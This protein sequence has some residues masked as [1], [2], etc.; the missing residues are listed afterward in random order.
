MG[1]SNRTPLQTETP[2]RRVLRGAALL[3]L[4]LTLPTAARASAPARVP[5]GVWLYQ[6]EA[7]VKI[8]DCGGLMCGRIQWLQ[9]PRNA[10]GQLDR[11][12]HNPDP[13]LRQRQLCGV[14]MIWN[15]HPDGPSRWRDGWFYNPDDGVTYRVA[16]ELKPDDQLVVRIYLGVPFIGETKTLVRVRQGVSGGWC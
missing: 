16:A 14:R 3:V 15:L 7:A 2:G 12:Y 8:F 13:A 5:Q 4:A 6:G 1:K 10:K 9:V 11:D